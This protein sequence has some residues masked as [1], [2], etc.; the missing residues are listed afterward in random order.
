MYVSD[1]L[2][3]AVRFIQKDIFLSIGGFDTELIAGEDY[4]LHRRIIEKYD[5]G[6]ID[7][8]ETHL[9][10]YKSIKEVAKKNFLYGK[11]IG[12]FFKKNKGRGIKQF[13]PFRRTYLSHYKDF[14]L[15]PSLTCGFV[16][17]Q[18]VRYSSAVV[19]MLLQKLL[20]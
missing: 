8:R 11:S 12:L 4:D 5:I 16:I 9:G 15:H 19:G 17:Y 7:A 18:A 3:V 6:R 14:I 20:H 1:D 2:R 10:E 13:S